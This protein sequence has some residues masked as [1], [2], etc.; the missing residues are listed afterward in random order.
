MAMDEH[1]TRLA[2]DQSEELVEDD[3]FETPAVIW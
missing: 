1:L 2:Q 3:F